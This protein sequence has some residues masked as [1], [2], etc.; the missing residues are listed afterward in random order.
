[1]LIDC[2]V[3]ELKTIAV[4]SVCVGVILLVSFFMKFST[5]EVKQLEDI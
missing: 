1:M 2:R 5:F 3:E 4:I